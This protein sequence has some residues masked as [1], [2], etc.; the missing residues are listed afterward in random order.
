M[1]C[2][3]LFLITLGWLGLKPKF[4]C[5]LGWAYSIMGDSRK[6]LIVSLVILR[7][8]FSTKLPKVQLGRGG[9][10]NQAPLLKFEQDFLLPR[11]NFSLGSLVSLSQFFFQ[12][13]FLPPLPLFIIFLEWNY[14]A[15][16]PKGSKA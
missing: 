7:W 3:G 13:S 9:Y 1:T 4:I 16:N 10:H 11:T 6:R 2:G 14:H 8:C 15:P 12:P 5:I